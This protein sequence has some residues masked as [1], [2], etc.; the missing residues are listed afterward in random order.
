LETLFRIM[1]GEIGFEDARK[2][3]KIQV[4]H[5]TEADLQMLR[6]ILIRI[7]DE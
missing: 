5:G 1:W 6:K 3:G 4:E 2:A 7:W